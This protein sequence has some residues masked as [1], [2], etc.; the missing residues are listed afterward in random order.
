MTRHSLLPEITLIDVSFV[1]NWVVTSTKCSLAEPAG[2]TTGCGQRDQS[3]GA[4]YRACICS[5]S[6]SGYCS[7]WT[8]DRFEI[9]TKCTAEVPTENDIL[10]SQR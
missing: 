1:G 2:G 8:I 10:V 3:L 6:S 4:Q 9:R 7:G 5:P